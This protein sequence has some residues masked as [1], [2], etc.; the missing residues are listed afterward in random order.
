MRVDKTVEINRKS[1][2]II[3]GRGLMEWSLECRFADSDMI[4][5]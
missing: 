2:T 1:G 3:T 4:I 5:F